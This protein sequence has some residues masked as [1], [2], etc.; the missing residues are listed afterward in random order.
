MAAF[1]QTMK[2]AVLSRPRTQ[3]LLDG[4]LDSEGLPIHWVPTKSPLGVGATA[5]E[6]EGG[7]LSGGFVGGEMSI[8]SFLQAKAQ[9]ASLSALPVFLKR[10]LPQRSLICSSGSTLN[11]PQQ[12]VG[13]RLGLV[14]YTS[15]M[16]TWMRGLLEEEYRLSRSSPQWIALSPSSPPAHDEITFI[17]IPDN[18]VGE[19]VEA[20]EEL[21]GYSHQL[22]RRECFLLSLLEKGELDA[23]I[24]YQV[25]I[26]SH[27]FKPLLQTEEGLWSHYQRRGVYPI[28]HVFVVQDELIRE[29]PNL[30]RVL[31]SALREA[32]KLWVDYLPKENRGFM[33]NEINRLGWD[34]F[35][36]H[37]GE[38]E[39]TTLETLVDYLLNDKMISR[40]I[41]IEELFH[42][43]S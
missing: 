41:S 17:Q 28:N 32:R 15:S 29:T 38:V 30:D 16:P 42:T 14:N 43:T 6:I 27:E 31:L 21:D 1:G 22:D 9:G 10:G 19:E 36:Y 37:L 7:I 20:W 13:K 39:R 24:S 35:A 26:G 2:F 3:A 11:S 4:K 25:R 40:R 12:L 34:P 33:E 8:S 18:F 5:E 23:V